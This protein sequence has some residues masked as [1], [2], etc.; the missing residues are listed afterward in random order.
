[1]VNWLDAAFASSLALTIFSGAAAVWLVAVSKEP[2]PSNARLAD[3]F[4]RVALVGALAIFAL[5]GRN[6]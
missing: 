5:L 2:D 3:Y 1:M 4:A 6:S